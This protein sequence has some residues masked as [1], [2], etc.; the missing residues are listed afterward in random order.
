MVI[1]IGSSRPGDKADATAARAIS[2]GLGPVK[3]F[4]EPQDL[5]DALVDGTI[6]AAVRGT[7]FAHDVLPPLLRSTGATTADRV[8]LMVLDPARAFML[9][10][11]GIDEGRDIEERWQ[12][13]LGT[14][15]LLS[16]LGITPR[17]TVISKGRPEDS[18]RGEDIARYLDEAEVLRS[19]A[20]AEGIEAEC[21]GILVERAVTSGNIVIAPDGVAGNLI[22]RSLHHIG[23]ME[24]WGAV[25]LGILPTVYVDTSRDKLDFTGAVRMARA[26]ARSGQD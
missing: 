19:R 6:G 24:S 14:S 4:P 17:V 13:L 3:V 15:L 23:R 26:M 10:P 9:A 25:A 5:V 7:L 11:V 8:C 20:E 18:D 16:S 21:V 12:L 2:S 1:G 22:F